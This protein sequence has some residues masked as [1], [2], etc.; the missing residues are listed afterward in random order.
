MLCPSIATCQQLGD[1][2]SPIEAYLEDH[3]LP[4]ALATE[5]RQRMKSVSASDRLALA[6]RLGRIYVQLIDTSR[7][8]EERDRLEE[9]GK[10]LLNDVP[11]ADSFDLRISLAK[12][13]YMYAE[14][15][16]INNKLELADPE[17]IK[18]A[19]AI[20]NETIPVFRDVASKTNRQVELI[21][22][23]MESVR[24]ED[25]AGAKAQLADAQRLRSIASYYAGWSTYYLGS[26][27]KNPRLADDALRSFGWLLNAQDGKP[28]SVERAPVS[29]FRLDHVARAAMGA[30]LCEALRG[31]TSV[32][33]R[34]L[35]LVER[36]EEISDDIRNQL[37][38]FR[39]T[40]LCDGGRWSDL[41]SAA[42]RRRK[43]VSGPLDVALARLICVAALRSLESGDTPKLAQP[44][45][46]RISSDALADLVELGEIANVLDI[47]KTFGA[48]QLGDDGFIVRYVRGLVQFEDAKEARIQAGE[49]LELPSKDNEMRRRF[50]QAANALTGALTA[51]DSDGFSSL[52]P[53]LGLMAG[54][55]MFQ[56]AEFAKAAEH[57]EKTFHLYPDAGSAEESLWLAIVSLDQDQDVSRRDH[58]EKITEL[59]AVFLAKFPAGER[60]AT[61]V[62]RDGADALIDQNKAI[63]VLLG[64]PSSSNLYISAQQ[65][66]AKLLYKRYRH[67]RGSERDISAT[68]FLAVADRILDLY[69]RRMNDANHEL[70]D[71][72]AQ[73]SVVLIRQM[74]D[75]VTGMPA[76]DISRAKAALALLESLRTRDGI[77]LS[78]AEDELELRRLQIALYEGDQETVDAIAAQLDSLGEPYD[79]I[80]A[81]VIF[82]HAIRMREKLPNDADTHRQVVRTGVKLIDSYGPAAEA[83]KQPSVA[84]LYARVADSASRVYELAGDKPMLDLA[85]RIDAQLIEAGHTSLDVLKR[86]AALAEKVN[87]PKLAYEAWQII[88]QGSVAS[89]DLWF[90]ARYESL[91]VLAMFDASRASLLMS[92]HQLLY[93]D[94][95]PEPWGTKLRTL[96][97][98]INKAATQPLPAQESEETR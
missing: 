59:A 12:A 3:N 34:W 84:G 24:L 66:V 29:Y 95:G 73:N 36:N 90:Q 78:E 30:G 45:V 92:Q 44:L 26:L 75:V 57:L 82:E 22:R 25:E 80:A 37:F 88:L 2:V 60:A 96:T 70:S 33:L 13:R 4:W 53:G 72:A 11:E 27:T 98:E 61:L 56:A 50:S 69:R 65:Q 8:P 94:Y 18:E 76:P 81:G 43:E 54:I 48:A 5:L 68:R 9:L 31:N 83:L 62:M 51:D 64:V 93:P 16:A 97:Q 15:I 40:M 10:Q 79:K 58:K 6:N 77:D 20:L 19:V 67:A 21:E 42:N 7:T 41:D 71:A 49:A 85:M 63:E 47:V 86:H 46:E 14:T 55:S 89:S 28:A 87:Q 32:A 39:I 17:K 74:L 91:R 23:R 35:D 52:H 1:N 38:M